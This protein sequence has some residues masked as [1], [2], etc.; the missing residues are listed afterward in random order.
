MRKHLK[1]KDRCCAMCKPH[2]RGH[3]NRWK[4]KDFA[5]L[6]EYE[7][8]KREWEGKRIILMDEHGVEIGIKRQIE[9][10]LK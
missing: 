1:N 5:Q 7:K 8:T 3:S 6:I 4:P 2:K 10:A 9:M